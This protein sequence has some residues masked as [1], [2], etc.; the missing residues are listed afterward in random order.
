MYKPSQMTPISHTYT[1]PISRPKKKKKKINEGKV[2]GPGL[3]HVLNQ[4][5]MKSNL[6]SWLLKTYNNFP[7]YINYINISLWSSLCFPII[8]KWKYK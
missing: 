3:D 8:T 7:D 6:S 2:C 1:K 5:L 4:H